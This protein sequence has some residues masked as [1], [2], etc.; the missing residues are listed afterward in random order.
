MPGCRPNGA[1]R[2]S[3][4]GSSGARSWPVRLIRVRHR[5]G[6]LVARAPFETLGTDNLSIT[7]RRKLRQTL[8]LLRA[9]GAS[10]RGN[11]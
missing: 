10:G 11:E 4:I 9:V 6:R 1:F 3:A 7:P 2:E 8:A 5:N